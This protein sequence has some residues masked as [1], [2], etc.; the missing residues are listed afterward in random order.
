VAPGA[1]VGEQTAIGALV[2]QQAGTT[3]D[4]GY[5]TGELAQAQAEDAV[6]ELA[7]AR[8]EVQILAGEVAEAIKRDGEKG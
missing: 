4:S 3:L 7:R 2:Q 1:Q 8:G 5:H 6:P